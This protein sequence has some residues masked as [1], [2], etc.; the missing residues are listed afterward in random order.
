MGASK[1]LVVDDEV[2]ILKV[3]NAELLQQGYE[4]DTANNGEEANNK[5]KLNKYDLVLLDFRMPKMDGMTVLRNIKRINPTTV[6][7]MMT[8]FGTIK[9]AVEAIKIGAYDYL[10]KPFDNDDMINKVKEALKV[11]DSLQFSKKEFGSNKIQLIGNSKRINNIKGKIEK[12]KDLNTTVLITGE[13]GT[14]KGVVAKSI[15][16][17]S[18]RRDLPFISVNCAVLPENLIESEL[19]GHEKGA[20]TGAIERKKGKFEIAGKGTIFLDEIATLNHNLQAKLLTVLQD[21]Q[22]QRV[23]GCKNISVQARIIAATNENLEYLVRKREF[24]EDLY[25]RLNVINIECPPLRYRKE[26]IML[27]VKFF[28]K[29]FNTKFNKKIKDISNEVE[30]VFFSYDW[31]GNV[32]ELE[33]TIESSVALSEGDILQIVDLPLRISSKVKDISIEKT[34][35]VNVAEELYKDQYTLLEIEELRAIKIALGKNN[36]HRKKTAEELGISRRTLQYK[37]KKFGI[38][39]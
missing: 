1:I 29:K 31:P 10:T 38:V 24:R 2:T 9:N 33:N 11:K 7:I 13:S 6:V 27:L 32:R 30:N 26:D 3:I 17:L 22:I 19:F 20:F 5:I 21:K 14:G 18:N 34:N 36:G 15:H 39:K 37:L 8:A 16:D 25:Y 35:N 4:V 12:I 28:M 23:G